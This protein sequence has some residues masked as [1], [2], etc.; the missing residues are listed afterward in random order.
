MVDQI[1][2]FLGLMERLAIVFSRA[3]VNLWTFLFQH[4]LSSHPLKLDNHFSFPYL[5]LSSNP[6]RFDMSTLAQRQLISF[7]TSSFLLHSCFG[8]LC[9]LAQEH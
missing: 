1:D 9:M 3:F 4:Y 8:C 6:R 7:L 5:Q 2:D